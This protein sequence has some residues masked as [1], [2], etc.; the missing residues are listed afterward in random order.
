T[1]GAGRGIAT[2]AGLKLASLCIAAGTLGVC[3]ATGVI[4]WVIP[5]HTSPARAAAPTPT[6]TPRATPT[7]TPV[8]P[9]HRIVVATPTPTPKAHR[10]TRKSS[11]KTEGG[12]GPTSH[13]RSLISQARSGSAAGGAS[14]FNPTSRTGPASPAPVSRAPGANEFQ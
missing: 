12:T 10:Q 13:E 9:P 11:T 14:E 6:P 3:A 1:G 2:A 5:H 7:P 8:E 4:P